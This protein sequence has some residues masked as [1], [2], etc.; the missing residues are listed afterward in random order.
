MTK[1]LSSYSIKIRLSLLFGAPLLA[2]LFIAVFMGTRLGSIEQ[3]FQEF[4]DAGVKSQKYTLMIS[5]D[6]NYVSRLTRSIMLADTYGKNMEKLDKRIASIYSHFDNLETTTNAI[7]DRDFASTYRKAIQASKR[8]TGT[9]LEDG[10]SRMLALRGLARTDAVLKNAWLNYKQAASPLANKARKSFRELTKLEDFYLNS[11]QQRANESISSVLTTLAYTAVATILVTII[12]GW[13]VIRSITQP[14][15]YLQSTIHNIAN[16]SD[17]TLRLDMQGKDE[18][19][20]TATAFNSMLAKFESIIDKIRGS[21]D[22]LTDASGDMSNIASMTSTGV[23]NQNIQLEQVATAMN[24]MTATVQEVSRHA[25]EAAHAAQTADDDA[26]EGSSV[27]KSTIENIHSLAAEID[28]SNTVISRLEKES[29]AI[30]AV[31]D[32]IRGVSEQTNLLALNAAIEAARA[33]EHGRGF[34]VV[35]DEVRV[36]ASRTQES[37]QEIQTMIEGLQQGTADAVSAMTSSKQ[38]AA[39]SVQS[40]LSAG[41]SLSAITTAVTRIRQMNEQIASAAEEQRSVAEEINLSIT[42][43]N[44]ISEKTATGTDQN[45]TASLQVSQLAEDLNTLTSQFK[46]A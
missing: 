12:F 19:S 38:H 3:D 17:L 18:L 16:N 6:M 4:N 36:L 30:G 15:N 21:S 33:G 34:A 39:E 27:V 23:K 13:I 28:K 40:A 29:E 35:A 20:Y 25:A 26:D 10:R 1:L 2:L 42:N 22:Q 46:T 45:S 7:N 9:F 14:I 37:T 5:R 31:L 8:D 32:V 41:N 43:I 44:E 24:Q 11:T